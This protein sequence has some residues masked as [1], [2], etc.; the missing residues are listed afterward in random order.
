MATFLVAGHETT[1]GTLSFL[2]YHLLHNPETY[3][4][5]QQEVDQVLGN[6]TLTIDHLPKLK[7][8]D[9]CI[10]ETLRF[11]SPITAV[12]RRA[13]AKT[14]I[15]GKYEIS[16]EKP[17]V[18]NLKGL[19]HDPR[20]WG[21]DHDLF[22][23]ERMLDFKK[24][25]AGAWRPFGIGMRS[26]IGRA[27]AEQEMIMNV[28]LILQRFQVTMADPSYHMELKST[29]TVKPKD[30]EIK[31][32]R[33]PGKSGM[34]GIG[35]QSS[36]AERGNHEI[37]GEH[38][39]TKR[40]LIILYGSNAGSCKSYAE[41]LAGQSEEH[42]YDAKIATLDSACEGFTTDPV[43]IIT[44]SY[45]GKPTD[46]AKKFVSW[47]ETNTGRAD[48]LK[49]AKYS[50]FGVGN[51]EWVSTYQR[52]PKLIDA[53]LSKLGAERQREPG[54]VDVKG[55]VIGPWEE[56]RDDLWKTLGSTSAPAVSNALKVEMLGPDP[57]AEPGE[58][59]PDLMTIKDNIRLADNAVGPEKMHMEVELPAD[60]TY[61]PGRHSNLASF[62][63]L[64]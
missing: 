41:D 1:S 17:I 60:T 50:V 23:P 64:C 51:S 11:Q 9:A 20:I 6:D 61:R 47:I 63:R 54:F 21:D 32:R 3:H 55:D 62:T 27:F 28:A 36:K 39:S 56:W 40:P 53:V 45:E 30:F 46:N 42:G 31:V 58:A 43:V 18:V 57:G 49:G 37:A 44:A 59:K 29:L 10:K 12:G 26:C 2:F 14:K 48:L 22:R 15:A 13:K 7:Y 24:Y 35:A 4:K 5:A 52:I 33:R 25:P 16:P 34:V 8:I 38:Q 19:H